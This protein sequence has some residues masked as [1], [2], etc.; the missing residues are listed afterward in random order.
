MIQEPKSTYPVRNPNTIV[1]PAVEECIYCGSTSGKLTDEHIVPYSL[2][3]ILILPKASCRACAKITCNIE[4]AVARS[5]FGNFRLKHNIKSRRKKERPDHIQ[6]QVSA[7]IDPSNFINV[8]VEDHPA[9][10]FM[11]KCL[12]AGILEG[13]PRNLDTSGSWQLVGIVGDDDMAKFQDKYGKKATFTFRHVPEQFSRTLAKI[14]YSYAVAILGLRSFE[15]LAPEFILGDFKNLSYLIGGSLDIAPPIPNAGHILE[16]H[17][18]GNAHKAFVI[19]E[20]RLFASL[21]TPSYHAVVG[22][23][24]GEKKINDFITK[25]KTQT[26]C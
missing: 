23:L 14:G 18:V 6:V 4:G 2:N 22:E 1:Y 10:L 26:N 15:P 11:L 17:I 16:V 9:P 8:P 19:V 21:H 3:G 24:S 5:V 13:V 25:I 20:I 12:R 7:S